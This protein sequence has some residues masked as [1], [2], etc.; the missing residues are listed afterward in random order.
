MSSAIRVRGADA[1]TIALLA[2]VCGPQI[3][4]EEPADVAL[5][6]WEQASRDRVRHVASIRSQ[7][8]LPVI[9]ILGDPEPTPHLA[10]MLMRH[11]DG[12][13]LRAKFQTSLAPTAAAVADG[14]TVMPNAFRELLETPALSAREKQIL[15]MVVLDMPNSEIA[16]KLHVTESNVKNHLSSAFAKLGV[17]SRAAAAALIV[18]PDAGLGPGILRITPANPKAE[19]SD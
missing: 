3:V 6:Y 18:D 19:T 14:Q 12:V 11:V 5:V 7:N 17:R 8:G 9:V 4:C 1:E 10:R 15:A 16:S 13:V 2:E